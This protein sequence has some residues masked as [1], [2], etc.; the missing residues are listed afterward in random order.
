[1]ALVAEHK[2]VFNYIGDQIRNK[3]NERLNN[4][5]I[6]FLNGKKASF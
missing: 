3:V 2:Y 1:M 6:Y 5:I 4:I